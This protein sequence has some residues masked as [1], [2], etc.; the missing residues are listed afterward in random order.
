MYWLCFS[1]IFTKENNFFNFQF[2]S[3]KY[4]AFPESGKKSPLGEHCLMLPGYKKHQ[5]NIK[6]HYDVGK[7]KAKL[8]TL[9]QRKRTIKPESIEKRD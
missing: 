1:G 4:K 5:G 3:L 8:S 2:A 7:I 9:V 6:Q